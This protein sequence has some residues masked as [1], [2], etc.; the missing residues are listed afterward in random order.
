M[1][2]SAATTNKYTF[3]CEQLDENGKVVGMTAK[4]ITTD[5]ETWAGFDGPMYN[6]Q[7]FLRGCGFSFGVNDEIGIMSNKNGEDDFRS[8]FV[9]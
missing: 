8:A 1:T 5:C 9:W 7:E 2:T 4:S 6:F 3:I